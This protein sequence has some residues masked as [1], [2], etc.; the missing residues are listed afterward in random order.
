MRKLPTHKGS[1]V[2]YST[3]LCLLFPRAYVAHAL[4]ISTDVILSKLTPR[5]TLKLNWGGTDISLLD[6]PGSQPQ[7]ANLVKR[8]C[9]SWFRAPKKPLSVEIYETKKN[10]GLLNA[11]R[12]EPPL[13]P[14][15][16]AEW[17]ERLIHLDSPRFAAITKKT[18]SSR[19]AQ[20]KARDFTSSKATTMA[21][22]THSTRQ[23]QVSGTTNPGSQLTDTSYR[24]LHANLA[25]SSSR[26]SPRRRALFSSAS[27]TR[28]G[29]APKEHSLRLISL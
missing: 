16:Y 12:V 25:W 15:P 4:P 2:D 11:P 29:T 23:C 17:H 21:R 22:S 28:H 19:M 6:Q 27:S 1:A 8:G 18:E 14:L 20:T 26:R 10:L 3:T 5:S 24:G 9:C 13:I 7:G